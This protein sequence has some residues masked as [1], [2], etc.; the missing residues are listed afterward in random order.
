MFIS[1]ASHGYHVDGFQ[2]VPTPYYNYNTNFYYMI[3]VEKL[4]RS[5]F[6]GIANAYCVTFFACCREVKNFTKYQPAATQTDNKQKTR[7]DNVKTEKRVCNFIFSFGCMPGDGVDA[8][9]KYV[10]NLLDLF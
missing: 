1:I 3:P 9:T 5:T 8:N 6:S 10:K 2:E 7:G 4:V